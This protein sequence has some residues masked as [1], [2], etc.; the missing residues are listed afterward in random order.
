MLVVPV[1]PNFYQWSASYGVSYLSPSRTYYMQIRTTIQPSAVNTY[2]NGTTETR[3]HYEARHQRWDFTLRYRF[4]RNYAIE[5]VGSNIFE[6][7][8]RKFIQGGRVIQ[9]RDYGANYLLTFSA[10]LDNVRLPFTKKSPVPN[11]SFKAAPW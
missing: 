1:A 11:L 3:Q 8:S 6:D 9:Q 5:F 7:P 2:A 4:N 10:N